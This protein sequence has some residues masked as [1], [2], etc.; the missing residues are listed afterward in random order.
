MTR[1]A[2]NRCRR[3]QRVAI[4]DGVKGRTGM[5]Q[6]QFRAGN[7]WTDGTHDR[8]TIQ[9]F[10]GPGQEDSHHATGGLR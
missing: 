5:A 7:K 10:L 6:F 3:T 2:R 4:I 1:P 9:G 8:S